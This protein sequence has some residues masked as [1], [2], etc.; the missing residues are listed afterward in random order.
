MLLTAVRCAATAVVAAIGQ[1]PPEMAATLRADAWDRF[2]YCSADG[3]ARVYLCQ[4]IGL[5]AY[6]R[7]I[8]R[9]A[10]D[11]GNI[12][13]ETR[14]VSVQIYDHVEALDYAQAHWLAGGMIVFSF[15]I[16]LL[17]YLTS[18]KAAVGSLQLR[19]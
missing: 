9:G 18:D 11:W 2:P 7:G 4:C 12:P 19:S 5:C 8:W 6:A 16:L 3:V 14:V 15:L 1:R 17:L 13:G 10:N